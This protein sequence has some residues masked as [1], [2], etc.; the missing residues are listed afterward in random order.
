MC[1]PVV[2]NYFVE[3]LGYWLT[4]YRFIY[5]DRGNI[6]VRFLIDILFSYVAKTNILPEVRR[7]FSSINY[8]LYKYTLKLWRAIES[9]K[10][11]IIG[12]DCKL[13]FLFK[14]YKKK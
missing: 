11:W 4:N 14:K 8:L 5:V 10:E 2:S 1:S 13:D 3:Y 12:P 9:F 7:K 6:C